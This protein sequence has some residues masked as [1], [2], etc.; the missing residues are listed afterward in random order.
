[1][2]WAA[3][4]GTRGSSRRWWTSRC[5][6]TRCSSPRTACATRSIR[7]RPRPFLRGPTGVPVADY[8]GQRL[9][10]LG[11]KLG[12]GLGAPFGASSFGHTGFTGTSIWVDPDLDLVVVLLTNRVHPSRDRSGAADLRREVSEAVRAAIL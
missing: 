6:R 5:S 9:G 4:P 12:G 2:R 11:Q 3:S 1:M 7:P 10:W 8:A